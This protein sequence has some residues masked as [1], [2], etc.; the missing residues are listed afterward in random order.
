MSLRRRLLLVLLALSAVGLLLAGA[1]SIHLLRRALVHQKDEQL[2]QLQAQGSRRGPGDG[3]PGTGPRAGDRARL[4]QI[5]A[6]SKTGCDGDDLTC[7]TPVGLFVAIY[8]STGAFLR[9]DRSLAGSGGGAELSPARVIAGHGAPFTADAVNGGT[10]Y[11]VLVEDYPLGY[12]AVGLELNDVDQTVARF[13]RTEVEIAA[14]VLAAIGLIAWLL[15]RLGLRPLD[16]MTNTAAAIAEGDLTARVDT[17]HPKTEVGRLGNSLNTMLGRIEASFNEQARAETRLRR[18]VGDASH[19]LRTPLTSIRGYAELMRSGV[20]ADDPGRVNALG[21]IESEAARMGVLV[22][23]LLL[24]ARL[25]QGRPLERAPVDL[26][27]VLDNAVADARVSDP[28]RTWT[29]QHGGPLAVVGDH[30]KLQQVMSNLLANARTHTPRGTAIEIDLEASATEAVVTV[31]DHGPGIPPDDLDRIFERF[32]RLDAGRARAQ[33]GTGL[34]LSIVRSIVESH[35]GTV[36]VANDA[37]GGAVFTVRLPL[38]TELATD[39]PPTASS[40]A[41]A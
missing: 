41:T 20:V 15:V 2:K 40:P 12:R 13:I 26:V 31:R 33:G 5:I 6:P 29:L 36:A 39:A 18:F 34:G 8:D 37:T 38:S 3:G 28:D 11:R 19:E 32:A 17:S 4:P 9:D 27:K 25:D 22:E 30:Q 7:A 10:H 16:R 14:V 21:R 35:N 23:D 1:A 24:L